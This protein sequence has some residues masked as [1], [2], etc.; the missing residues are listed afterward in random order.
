MGPK[1]GIGN[2]TKQA[3]KRLYYRFQLANNFVEPVLS[4][5]AP[6]RTWSASFSTVSG[7]CIFTTTRENETTFRWYFTGF[8]IRSY[9]AFDGAAISECSKREGYEQSAV[10]CAC[11]RFAE[12]VRCMGVGAAAEVAS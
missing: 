1:S 8:P 7:C 4:I 12:R 5:F 2:D 6:I 11:C 10:C 3:A 9:A